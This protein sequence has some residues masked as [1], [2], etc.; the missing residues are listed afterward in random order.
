VRTGEEKSEA[1]L[2]AL[3]VYLIVHYFCMRNMHCR[4][5]EA[6]TQNYQH[7]VTVVSEMRGV[8]QGR[9]V[10]GGLVDEEIPYSWVKSRLLMFHM[11]ST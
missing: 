8:L 5:K 10:G 1:G 3:P 2:C 7:G 9:K 4:K 6:E 11:L